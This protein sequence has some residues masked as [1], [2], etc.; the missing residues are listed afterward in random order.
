MVVGTAGETT[1][2]GEGY[3]TAESIYMHNIHV[4]NIIHGCKWKPQ[5]QLLLL[6]LLFCTQKNRHFFREIE[7]ER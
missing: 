4:C 7:S 5:I 2:E 6:L 3:G 1:G